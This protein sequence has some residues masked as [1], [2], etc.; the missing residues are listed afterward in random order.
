MSQTFQRSSGFCQGAKRYESREQWRF[1]NRSHP[2]W[3]NQGQRPS[4]K[5][6]N[7]KRSWIGKRKRQSGYPQPQQ[8]LFHALPNL[9]S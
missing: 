9:G 3:I 7:N 4:D 2:P 1:G 8:A 5:F 6:Q